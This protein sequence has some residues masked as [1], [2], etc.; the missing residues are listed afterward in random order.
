M[1]L[2]DEDNFAPN[3]DTAPHLTTSVI[4]E[5][6]EADKFVKSELFSS[7]LLE[8]WR[9]KTVRNANLIPFQY[10]VLREPLHTKRAI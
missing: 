2:T 1:M 7:A 3:R 9:V 6:E 4:Q 10:R 8:V 5:E